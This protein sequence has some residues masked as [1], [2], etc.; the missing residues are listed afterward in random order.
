MVPHKQFPT[1]SA[2]QP[3]KG[4]AAGGLESAIKQYVMCVPVDVARVAEHDGDAFWNAASNWL[5]DDEGIPV[6]PVPPAL[7]VATAAGNGR[8]GKGV[9]GGCWSVGAASGGGGEDAVGTVKG[10]WGGLAV[11]RVRVCATAII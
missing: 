11:L 7:W 9:G 3:V 1:W 4:T 5:F 8:A 2:A 10:A 6:P